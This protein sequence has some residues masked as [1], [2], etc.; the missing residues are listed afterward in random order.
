[1]RRLEAATAVDQRRLRF[2]QREFALLMR[3]AR[4]NPHRTAPPRATLTQALRLGLDE[5]W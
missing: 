3:Q 4:G 2:A 1:M 5:S